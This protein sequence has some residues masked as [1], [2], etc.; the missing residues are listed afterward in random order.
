MTLSNY[1]PGVTGMES[2]FGTY[3]KTVSYVTSSTMTISVS[4]DDILKHKLNDNDAFNMIDHVLR[5]INQNYIGVKY[6]DDNSYKIIEVD[7]DY[8]IISFNVIIEGDTETDISNL[9]YDDDSS[10]I[11][12]IKKDIISKLNDYNISSDEVELSTDDI[13]YDIHN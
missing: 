11:T 1:P 12:D 7:T 6:M 13:E 8:I 2:I 10:A 3:D 9:S 4:T 5:N